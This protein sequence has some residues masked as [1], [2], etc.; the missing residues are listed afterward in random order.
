MHF[1]HH[2]KTS[3]CKT[4]KLNANRHISFLNTRLAIVCNELMIDNY[5]NK[6]S[7][8]SIFHRDSKNGEKF[9]KITD[10]LSRLKNDKKFKVEK[11]YSE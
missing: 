11:L 8:L 5:F 1:K 7:L 3:P 4:I 2:L 9:Q 10:Y 6:I